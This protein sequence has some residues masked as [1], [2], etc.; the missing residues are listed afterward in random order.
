MARPIHFDIHA[1]DPQKSMAF[2]RDAFDWYFTPFGEN[3]T[4]WLITTGDHETFGIDGGLV[5]RK[6]PAPE[7]GAPVMGATLFLEVDDIDGA[8]TKAIAAGGTEAV[9]KHAVPGVGWSAF[10]KDPDG[11]VVGLF[12]NNTEAR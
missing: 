4:Y 1:S 8:H 7:P 2:Y 5:K 11:N 3:G 10:I 9:A 12:E 6:G